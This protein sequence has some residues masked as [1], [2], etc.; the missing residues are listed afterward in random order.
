[1]FR[2]SSK[3]L[4]LFLFAI[5]ATA[6]AQSHTGEHHHDDATM[7][8]RFTD[9][10]AW[11]DRFEDPARDAWQLPDRIVET[12][13]D[14]EDLV[15][16][17][18]GS[19]TGYFPVRFARACPTGQVFG[20]DVEAEMVWYLN[21]RSR[22]EELSNLVSI[23]AAPDNP[24]LPMPV[25]LVFLCNTYHHIDN[26]IDYFS[27]LKDQLRLGG[28]VAVVDYSPSSRRGPP[29]KLDAEVIKTEMLAAGYTLDGDYDFLPDQYF[30]VFAGNDGD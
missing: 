12:L 27:R 10:E 18:I 4:C 5:S 30:L 29:H 19:A 9:A 15:I 13:V 2:Y 1:M 6:T 7:S 17:D 26:R 23:L 28:R 14:R 25:D 21:E 11:A 22:R 8:H 16:A 20:A 24:H 3:L